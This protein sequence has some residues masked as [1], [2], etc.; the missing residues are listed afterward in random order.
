[1]VTITNCAADPR[2]LL[3]QELHRMRFMLT[4]NSIA[5]AKADSKRLRN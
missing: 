2:M 4:I 1:M 3:P 5:L